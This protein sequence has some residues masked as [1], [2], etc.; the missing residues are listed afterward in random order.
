MTVGGFLQLTHQTCPVWRSVGRR[1]SSPGWSRTPVDR[2]DMAFSVHSGRRGTRPER[3]GRD[4]R[5]HQT[6]PHG[7]PRS[8]S[9]PDN[10]PWGPEKSAISLCLLFLR[11]INL[12]TCISLILWVCYLVD[13]RK[14]HAE[15]LEGSLNWFI[16]LSL[17]EAV[18]LPSSPLKY[19]KASTVTTLALCAVVLS[20]S[21]SQCTILC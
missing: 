18:V 14:T 13:S 1:S 17:S 20:Q 4:S 12:Q 15:V 11:L 16:S 21:L 6:P 9:R 5:R 8:G 19:C 3:H 2:C 10:Q 7:S